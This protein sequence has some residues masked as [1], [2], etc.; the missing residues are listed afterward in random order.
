M[1]RRP[2][3]VAWRSE[4]D[5]GVV[6]DVLGLSADNPPSYRFTSLFTL[7]EGLPDHAHLLR[8]LSLPLANTD[9]TPSAGKSISLFLLRL[10]NVALSLTSNCTVQCWQLAEPKAKSYLPC[11]GLV[12]P[13]GFP[14][15]ELR[16]ALHIV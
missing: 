3:E 5:G 14:S 16:H 2:A 13:L 1:G 6:V 4:Y 10:L 12:S 7:E 15:P 11:S 9:S 8:F